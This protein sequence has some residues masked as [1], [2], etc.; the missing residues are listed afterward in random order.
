[1]GYIKEPVGIDFFVDATPLT[2]AD[3]Q[4]I[5]QVITYFKTTG[6]KL[7]LPKTITRKRVAKKKLV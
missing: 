1:M 6:K 5:S 3:R 2:I 4:Q 7:I